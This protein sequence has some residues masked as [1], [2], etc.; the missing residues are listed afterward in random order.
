[1]TQYQE[2]LL[3]LCVVKIPRQHEHERERVFSDRRAIEPRQVRHLHLFA[4]QR[5][6]EVQRHACRT[7]LHP[8]KIARLW[9]H[10]HRDQAIGDRCCGQ[11]LFKRGAIAGVDG[12]HVCKLGTEAAPDRV[13]R[14]GDH[15]QGF[16]MSH[17]VFSANSS[18][19]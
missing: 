6:A 2:V 1:M 5:I 13:W 12:D 19:A 15:E 4:R 11:M 9:Q 16:S 18:M 10:W 17:F 8:A 7:E 3:P 14:P